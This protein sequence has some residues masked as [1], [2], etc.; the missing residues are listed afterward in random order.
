MNNNNNSNSNDMN[1]YVTELNSPQEVCTNVSIMNLS[2]SQNNIDNLG[3]EEDHNNL[4]KDSNDKDN[5]CN[6][7]SQEI[8][9]MISQGKTIGTNINNTHEHYERTDISDRNSQSK[10]TDD[11][12]KSKICRTEMY[13]KQHFVTEES[14][15]NYSSSLDEMEKPLKASQKEIADKLCSKNELIN[16]FFAMNNNASIQNNKSMSTNE[17]NT[18]Q[19]LT[20]VRSKL[21]SNL[22]N[23]LK[24]SYI[25][26]Y[27]TSSK[28]QTINS[29]QN[30]P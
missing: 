19:I 1:Y 27:H 12:R 18:N 30:D 15:R 7:G 26:F 16:P 23:L 6:F 28:N 21:D 4:I 24:F 9:R 13:S 20:K 11:V 14:S 17:I 22:Q 25:D 3:N 8:K 10:E 5:E 29:Q 2:S